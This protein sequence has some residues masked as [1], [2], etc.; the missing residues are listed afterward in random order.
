M[1]Q[2]AAA[3]TSAKKI[4]LLIMPQTNNRGQPKQKLETYEKSWL[5]DFSDHSNY[6][7]N[8]W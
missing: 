5:L 1:K 8:T 7:Y 3:S 4:W 2:N 6:L